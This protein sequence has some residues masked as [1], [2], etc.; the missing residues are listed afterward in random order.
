MTVLSILFFVGVMLI[1]G[2]IDL[3]GLG[4]TPGKVNLL[5]NTE[6]SVM[7]EQQ[8]SELDLTKEGIPMEPHNQ[9]Y[10]PGMS[11]DSGMDYGVGNKITHDDEI[12]ELSEDLINEIY[13]KNR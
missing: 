5:Y 1:V 11:F 3:F 12:K 7:G 9:A 6:T 8:N 2:F 13:A 10:N 4:L